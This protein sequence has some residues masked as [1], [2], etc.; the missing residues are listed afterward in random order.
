MSCSGC[1]W[2]VSRSVSVTPR[3]ASADLSRY[4]SRCHPNAPFLYVDYDSDLDRVRSSSK[5][6]LLAILCVG[7]RFWSYSSRSVHPLQC[8]S[9]SLKAIGAL[10]GF[11]P[12]TTSSSAFWTWRSCGSHSDLV[13]TTSSSRPSRDFCCA[14]T[15]CPLTCRPTKSNTASGFRR[16][17][18]GSVSVWLSDG[19]PSS[20][21]NGAVI[22]AFTGSRASQRTMR[23]GIALCCTSPKATTSECTQPYHLGVS[24]ESKQTLIMS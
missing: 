16:E 21:W 3:R 8:L 23:G 15:G 1:R 2:L 10:A 22:S 20:R 18:H 19:P 13:P 24:P 11:T 6:L 5:I 12:D 14:R 17:G 4:F 9:P 7:A